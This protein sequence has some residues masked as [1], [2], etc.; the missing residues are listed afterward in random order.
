MLRRLA[1]VMFAMLTVLSG[2]AACALDPRPLALIEGTV[3]DLGRRAVV[4]AVV[5]ISVDDAP[6]DLLDGVATTGADG[7]FTIILAPTEALRAH[8]AERGGVIEFI[9]SASLPDGGFGGG[10]TFSRMPTATGWVG[11]VPAVVLSREGSQEAP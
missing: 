2:S 6:L 4:G 5:S 3:V 9:V 11:P 7:R 10:W 1:L 8:A